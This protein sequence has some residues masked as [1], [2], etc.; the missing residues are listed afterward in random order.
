MGV[1]G[2]AL[3]VGRLMLA[4]AAVVVAGAARSSLDSTAPDRGDDFWSVVT[5]AA[6]IAALGVVGV[7]WWSASLSES[8]RRLR[9]RSIGAAWMWLAWLLPI[10]WVAAASVTLLRIDVRAE[11]DP[12]PGIAVL[13][14][15]ASL[16]VPYWLTQ[17]AIRLVNHRRSSVTL[18]LTYVCDLVTFGSIWYLLA[19]WPTPLPPAESFGGQGRLTVALVGGLLLSLMAV[20]AV[21]P[22]MRAPRLVRHRSHQLERREHDDGDAPAWFRSGLAGGPH[23]LPAGA[24]AP[25]AIAAGTVVEG[26]LAGLR[27]MRPIAV[28]LH[29]AWAAALFVDAALV[30][31]VV[32]TN[33]RRDVLDTFDS[34]LWTWTSIAIL[35]TLG[36]YLV[37]QGVW[38]TF[39]LAHT[40]RASVFSQAPMWLA[41][42]YLPFPVLAVVAVFVARAEG[43]DSGMLV[44]QVG[45]GIGVLAL[46]LSIRAVRASAVSLRCDTTNFRLW[47][48]TFVGAWAISYVRGRVVDQMDDVTAAIGISAV[49]TVVLAAMVGGAAYYA[50]RSMA[51]LQHHLESRRTITRRDLAVDRFDPAR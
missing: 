48:A 7:G 12:T 47:S 46:L 11:V 9:L 18:W 25:G 14:F 34:S 40:R 33:D 3:L 44:A 36:C 35:A 45:A 19:E 16:A 20:A 28:A 8:V 1:R 49:F 51:D 5:I 13:G 32:A 38:T 15:A 6:A 22:A 24:V 27:R 10:G 31:L 17:S 39:A 23:G 42:L 26:R 37:A 43:H 29:V 30:T 21:I 41:V 2:V 4:G 50:N